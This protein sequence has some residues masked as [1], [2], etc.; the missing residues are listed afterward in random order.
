MRITIL[1]LFT[2]LAFCSFSQTISSKVHNKIVPNIIESNLEN[3]SFRNDSI[4]QIINLINTTPPNDFR[5]LVI[6]KNDSLVLEEYFN[7]YWRGTIH[8]IRSAGKSV[9]ALLL[10]IALDKG[11]IKNVE[12]NIY[13][14]F[15]KY[16]K[17]EER[18][19][20]IKH[21]LI[22]SSGLDANV[23]NE[24]SEGYGLNWIFKN[25]WVKHVLNL[26]MI[27]KPGEKWVYNDA[28]AMIIGAIIE[29][30]SGQK[31]SDFANEYLFEPLGIKEYYWFTGSGGRTGAM[32]N[33]Y[34]STLD[35][36][37][38]GQLIINKG[39]CKGKQ[40]ISK[41]WI[42]EI[43]TSKM[44][45]KDIVPFANAYSYFWYISNYNANGINYDY[46]YA[47]GNGGNLLFV[48]PVEKLVV[49]LTSSAYG[50]GLGQ[51]R[52]NKIFQLI[53]ESIKN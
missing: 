38:I 41:S 53:L 40:I 31:L 1:L 2:C 50:E 39:M 26:S 20:R 15:P 30:Q 35:F 45:I 5:G 47:A 3:S 10:G 22:M 24:K 9:T 27:F 42:G 11:I 49:A 12:Q 52:S 6:I 34:I 4:T 36:A 16:K 44:N 13:D 28:A 32:G 19:I 17:D 37:K 25:D 43:S 18:D 23:F 46:L 33:L 8:D 14:F 48:V 21:L 7:T 51:F 29:K